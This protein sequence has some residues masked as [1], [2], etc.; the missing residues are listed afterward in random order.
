MRVGCVSLLHILRR[1]IASD[2]SVPFSLQGYAPQPPGLRHLRVRRLLRVNLIFLTCILVR[3]LMF[4]LDLDQ[5]S[6]FMGQPQNDTAYRER[7][8]LQSLL[9]I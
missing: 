1:M 2:I 9:N 8:V 6:G 4:H 7:S 5:Y 3:D